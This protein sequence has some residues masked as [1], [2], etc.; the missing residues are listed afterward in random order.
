MP[1]LCT[2]LIDPFNLALALFSGNPSLR[3][4]PFD[5]FA[6]PLKQR[7]SGSGTGFKVHQHFLNRFLDYLIKV[8]HFQSSALLLV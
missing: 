8:L 2:G 4:P 7:R 3:N 5:V 1:H 6:Q